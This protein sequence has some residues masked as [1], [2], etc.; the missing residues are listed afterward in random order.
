ML[1]GDDALQ[2]G[3]V[4]Q[5]GGFLAFDLDGLGRPA[6]GPGQP[7]G[8]SSERPGSAK[9]TRSCTSVVIFLLSDET[10]YCTGQEFTSTAASPA[11]G[12]TRPT[13]YRV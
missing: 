12:A 11:D 3:E 1:E 5:D 13:A 9:T 7:T 8:R 6:V 10:S 2:Y 4:L